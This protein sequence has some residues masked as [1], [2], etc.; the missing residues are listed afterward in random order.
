MGK[1]HSLRELN[2]RRNNLHALPEG[3]ILIVFTDM[4]KKISNWLGST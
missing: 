3:K 4:N 2:V 1:L